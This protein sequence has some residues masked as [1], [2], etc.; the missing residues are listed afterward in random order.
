LFTRGYF[1]DDIENLL[2][3]AV[4]PDAEDFDE[5]GPIGLIGLI[6]T[7]ESQQIPETAKYGCATLSH[8]PMKLFL[9]HPK[10]IKV[11]QIS[12]TFNK[13]HHFIQVTL[14]ISCSCCRSPL[15]FTACGRSGATMCHRQPPIELRGFSLA[16]AFLVAGPGGPGCG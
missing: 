12:T 5:V 16:Q 10:F 6:G 4:N 1:G 11:H 13:F 8:W 9:V 7:V 14:D 15:F 3:R 2:G